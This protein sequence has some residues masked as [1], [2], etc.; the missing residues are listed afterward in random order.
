[1]NIEIERK[2]LLKNDNWRELAE[3]THYAQCYL[4]Q[5]KSTIRVRIAGEHG[6]ITIKGKTQSFS[7]KEF[8]YEIPLEDAKELF[9][10]SHTA[11]VEKYRYKIPIGKHIWEVDEFLGDN[12][13]LVIAEIE[14]NSEDEEFDKPEWIGAEV[15]GDKR[16]YNSHLA[17]NPYKNW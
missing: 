17:E 4:N 1:M 5:K 10:F 16:Y 14:L 3:G 8:E 9:E 11:V 7:R 6:Y 13:G 12:K 15:T 2:F